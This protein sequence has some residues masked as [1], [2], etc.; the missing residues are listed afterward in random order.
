[1]CF[2][3]NQ[4]ELYSWL[5]EKHLDDE[6]PGIDSPTV[7]EIDFFVNGL[8]DVKVSSMDYRVGISISGRYYWPLLVHFGSLDVHC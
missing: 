3:H 8:S 1:M 7:V 5:K 6:P 2:R 4:Y